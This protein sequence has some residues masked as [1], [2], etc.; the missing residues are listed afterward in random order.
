MSASPSLGRPVGGPGKVR[1]GGS[2]ASGVLFARLAQAELA[3]VTANLRE[4]AERLGR[5]RDRLAALEAA[6]QS[7]PGAASRSSRDSRSSNRSRSS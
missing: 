3:A 6:V 5:F 7:S 4:L 1:D 2:P